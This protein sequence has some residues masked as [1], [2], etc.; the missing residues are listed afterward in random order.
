MLNSGQFITNDLGFSASVLFTRPETKGGKRAGSNTGQKIWDEIA[1]EKRCVCRIKNKDDL[2]CARA[3]VTMREFA[4]REQGEHHTFENILQD[5]CK[6]SQQLK[7][8]KKLLAEA[9]VPEGPCGLEDIDKFQNYLG[10]QGYRI[11][12]VDECKGGVIFKGE[13]FIEENKIIALVKS[14]YEDEN[15]DLKAHYDGLHSIPAFMNRSY[16]CKHC[17]KGYNTEDSTHHNCQAQNCPACKRSKSN[18][19]DGCKDFTLW[20][21]P[22]RSGIICRRDFYEENCFSHHLMKQEF[23]DPSLKRT[24]FPRLLK[25]KVFVT[26]SVNARIAWS[27]IK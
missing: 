13:K 6:N 11:I 15:G 4:K 24:T 12:V 14:V 17:C 27:R 8:A 2:C 18:D 23:E 16:F 26:R 1:K 22:D 20:A 25:R 19:D 10:P 21:K 3:I 9:D 5:R 7:E